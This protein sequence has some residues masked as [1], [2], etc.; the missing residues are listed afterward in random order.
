VLRVTVARGMIQ[1]RLDVTAD[2]ARGLVPRSGLNHLT[3]N[4]RFIDA[5]AQPV[6]LSQFDSTC[7]AT[8][9]PNGS[10]HCEMWLT[11]NLPRPGTRLKLE[12]HNVVLYDQYDHRYPITWSAQSWFVV[13]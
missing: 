7:Q 12:I 10:R 13:P 9:V 3:F 2:M 1:G 5:H 11:F 6:T 4:G 8:A